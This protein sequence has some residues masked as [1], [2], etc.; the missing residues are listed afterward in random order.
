MVGRLT[1]FMALQDIISI[2]GVYIVILFLMIFNFV[3][4]FSLN[5]VLIKRRYHETRKYYEAHRTIMLKFLSKKC[6]ELFILPFVILLI[7]ILLVLISLILLI[8]IIITKND[9]IGAIYLLILLIYTL[10][11][12]LIDNHYKKG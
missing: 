3:A 6:H 10:I 7:N 9:L 12:A 2:M 8:I 5:D 4:V 11:I 1:R